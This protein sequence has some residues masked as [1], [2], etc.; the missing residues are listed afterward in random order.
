MTERII[1]SQYPMM[2]VSFPAVSEIDLQEFLN[3][4]TRSSY[5][6]ASAMGPQAFYLSAK[7]TPME[8]AGPQGPLMG[9]PI[10]PDGSAAHFGLRTFGAAQT[11]PFS[12]LPTAYSVAPFPATSTLHVD[13]TSYGAAA[14]ISPVPDAKARTSEQSAVDGTRSLMSAL[15]PRQ[16]GKGKLETE[17]PAGFQYPSSN[18]ATLSYSEE[19]I[20]LAQ[21]RLAVLQ[22]RHMELKGSISPESEN[23]PQQPEDEAVGEATPKVRHVRRHTRKEPIAEHY[24]SEEEFQKA[25]TRW[26]E[27]RDNNNCAVRRSRVMKRQQTEIDCKHSQCMSNAKALNMLKFRNAVLLKSIR[28]PSALTELEKTELHTMVHGR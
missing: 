20:T 26:R 27:L 17:L 14:S 13:T 8:L 19:L 2:P 16:A 6:A 15:G 24:S 21:Q 4:A 22:Q 23:T 12:A 25:W 11:V 28:N 9:A 18:P 5:S 3:A 7:P 1:A 10:T